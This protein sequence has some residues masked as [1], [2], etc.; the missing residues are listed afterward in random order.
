MN[1]IAYNNADGV[2][3]SGVASATTVV[4]NAI[5]ANGG[6]NGDLGIDLAAN[7]VTVNDALDA[8]G[9]ATRSRTTRW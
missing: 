2:T 9:G 5:F 6:V 1:T 3:V 4:R 8:D 7:G